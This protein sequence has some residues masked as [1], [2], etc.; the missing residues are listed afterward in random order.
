MGLNGCCGVIKYLVILMNLLFWIIGLAIISLAIWMLTDPTFLISMTQNEKNYFI[1]LY[2]FLVVGGLMLTIALLGCCG[3][4]KESQC[5]LFSFFSCLLIVLVAEVAAGAWSYHNS[6]K[7]ETFVR[8]AVKEA[9]QDEYSVVASRTT[10]LDSIQK[11]FHCCGAEGPNDWQ[12]S[13]YNNADRSSFL[14]IAI[15]KLNIAYKVPKTCCVDKLSAEQCN[16]ARQIGIITSIASPVIYTDGCMEKLVDEIKKNIKLVYIFGAG[17]IGI[18]ILA[19]IFALFLCCAIR[20]N[21]S[22]KN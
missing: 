5:M 22:Y 10:A 19:I 1:G 18:E 2:I 11:Y 7:L 12:S 9:V 3:A 17:I 13:V 6:E 14:N 16:S 15:S 4:Y 8:A 21:N 20:R